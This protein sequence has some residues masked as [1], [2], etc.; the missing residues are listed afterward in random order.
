MLSVVKGSP[1]GGLPFI[2]QERGDLPRR[3]TLQFYLGGGGT[4]HIMAAATFPSAS[5]A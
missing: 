1:P 2:E 4:L 3:W 5:T